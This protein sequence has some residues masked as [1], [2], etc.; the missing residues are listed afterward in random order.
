MDT[1][2][3]RKLRR[4]MTDAERRLW[5]GLR[6]RRLN[7]L[8]F[9]RQQQI[10]PYFVDFFCHEAS[11]VV[12]ADGS[13]HQNEDGFW[14]DYKRTK[15]LESAGY[16]VVRFANVDILTHPADVLASIAALAGERLQS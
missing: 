2:R 9:R 7:G 10:G 6:D 11:F 8:K 12:E 5:S 15:W 13:Q 16:A 4:S 3:A 14:Y 1:G